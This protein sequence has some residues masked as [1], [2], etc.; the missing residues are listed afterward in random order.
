MY[1]QGTVILVPFPFT[2]LSSKK[3]R[4]AI[5]VSENLSGDDVVAV[6]ISSHTAKNLQKTEIFLKKADRNFGNTGLKS[7]P[8][9]KVSKIATLDKEIILG[10]LGFVSDEVLIEIQRRLKIVFGIR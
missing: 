8:V 4:P 5:I 7:D 6:F 3:V 9:V 1:K 2:D 10:E